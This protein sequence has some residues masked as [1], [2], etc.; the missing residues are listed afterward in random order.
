MPGNASTSVLRRHSDRRQGGDAHAGPGWIESGGDGQRHGR[1]SRG[2]TRRP[3]GRGVVSALPEVPDT[4]DGAEDIA[5]GCYMRTRI[6][7]PST[8]RRACRAPRTQEPIR[9]VDERAALARARLA[10][11]TAPLMVGRLDKLTSGIVLVAKT[12]A[13]HA[14]LQR[15]VA[16][17]ATAKDYLAVVYGKVNVAR[18]DIDLRLRRDPGDCRRVVASEEIGVPSLTRFVR[19]A[20]VPAPAAGLSLLRCRLSR[21]G[22]IRF[23]C[24]CRLVAGR[25]SAIQPMEN[26]AGGRSR[27]RS[28]R[29]SCATSPGRPFTRGG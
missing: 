3:R 13:I 10:G 5:I 6:C 12:A 25:W 2:R 17:T 8:S 7:W 24:T 14:S 26:R 19:L 21:A 4:A 15:T 29:R 22:R 18:G 11:A 27:I 9:H 16:S 1:S 23:A 20:R 28:G